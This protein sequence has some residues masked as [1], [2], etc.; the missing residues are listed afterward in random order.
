VGVVF[1]FGMILLASGRARAVPTPAAPASAQS[2]PG[3]QQQ[4]YTLPP[5]KLAK[6]EALGHI[7][8]VM[9]L[10]GRVWGLAV[11]WLLLQ[12]RL[13]ARLDAWV[14]RRKSPRWV[15]GLLYFAVLLALLTVADLPLGIYAQSVSLQYGISVQSWGSWLLDGAKGL[16]LTLGLG[17]PLMLL[18]HVIVRRAPR[19]YWLLGWAAAV[20][21]SILGACVGPLFEPIFN[22]FEPLAKSNPALV[23]R[24]EKVVERTGTAIPPERMYLMKASKK[25]NGLNAYVSGLGPTKRVVV[26]DTTAGR[27]PD[28]EVLFIFGHESGHYVLHHI[29]KG[30]ALSAVGLFFGFWLCA[31]VTGWLARRQTAWLP[32]ADGEPLLASR[33]GLMILLLVFSVGGTVTEP[34]SSAVSRHFEHEADIYGQEAMHGLLADPQKSAVSGFNALGEAWLEEPNPNPFVVFWTYDHPSIQQRATFAAQYDPWKNGGRGQ[35]FAK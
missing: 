11:L 21:L 10:V 16:A 7:R 26:W 35:F 25:T 33:A 12:T 18:F 32:L 31:R 2:G 29:P 5:D 1:L 30:L 9:L 23:A 6:A 8:N 27:I 3:S 15:Q 22:Q 24:L 19:R 13:A 4:A 28:D 20:V 17:A 34:I 14:A